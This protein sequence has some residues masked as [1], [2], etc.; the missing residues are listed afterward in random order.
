MSPVTGAV[1]NGVAFGVDGI[2]EVAAIAGDPTGAVAGVADVRGAGLKAATAIGEGEADGAGDLPPFANLPPFGVGV[3]FAATT[4]V[5]EG[6]ATG[7]CG[8]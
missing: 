6:V 4:G 8:T 7:G 5:G 2:G 1:A 3:A